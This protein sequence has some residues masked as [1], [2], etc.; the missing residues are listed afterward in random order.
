MESKRVFFVAWVCSAHFQDVRFREKT[1]QITPGKPFVETY[2]RLSW[3][4]S[5]NWG[6]DFGHGW[7]TYPTPNLPPL[8][9]SGLIFGLIRGKPALMMNL[10]LLRSIA[11]TQCPLCG[12][13]GEGLGDEGH[14]FLT[15]Q[16]VWASSPW[17][18]AGEPPNKST[19]QRRESLER[20]L[21]ISWNLLWFKIK[22]TT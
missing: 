14:Q 6:G 22:I 2:W 20:D 3:L 12:P 9:N 13:A 11:G 15:S 8:R 16:W 4:V 19:R 1:W 17:Q 7:S 18:H 5:Q 10:A 21:H